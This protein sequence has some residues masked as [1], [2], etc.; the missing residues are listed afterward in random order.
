MSIKAVKPNPKVE[1]E[2]KY[3]CKNPACNFDGK[4]PNELKQMKNGKQVACYS[5][6]EKFRTDQY[7]CRGAHDKPE[8]CRSSGWPVN[9]PSKFKAACPDAYSYAYDDRTSTFFCRNTNYELT[10]CGKNQ[11]ELK[12]NFFIILFLDFFYNSIN[13][14]S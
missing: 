10:F 3:W 1:G 5:A 14:N 8:T 12:I 13:T 7:C 9:Y 6:C 11:H 4:C 2:K